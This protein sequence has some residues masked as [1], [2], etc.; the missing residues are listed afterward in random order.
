MKKEK[1]RGKNNLSNISKKIIF[2]FRK[3]M[4]LLTNSILNDN[5]NNNNNNNHHNNNN[6]NNNN[7]KI[8]LRIRI[9]KL[10]YVKQ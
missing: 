10:K 4:D 7:S 2:I 8:S 9:W 1:D 6:N 3:S 5:I